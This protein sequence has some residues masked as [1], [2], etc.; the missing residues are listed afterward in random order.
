MVHIEDMLHT[1]TYIDVNNGGAHFHL[2]PTSSCVLVRGATGQS[3]AV[4][5]GK[6]RVESPDSLSSAAMANQPAPSSSGITVDGRGI[7]SDFAGKL[8]ATQDNFTWFGDAGASGGGSELD[9][10]FV[11]NDA[12]SLKI[13]ITGN[14]ETNGNYW[15][16]FLQTQPEGTGTLTATNGPPSGVI[17]T[18]Y[19]TMMDEGFE[20]NWCLCLNTSGGV[21]YVDLVDLVNN[22]CRYMGAAAVN[23][24]SGVLTGGTN[25]NGAL[26]AFDNTNTAGVTSDSGR[27]IEQTGIDAATATTG[28]EIS[29]PFADIGLSTSQV[30]VMALL[31]GNAG[32]ISDQSLPGFGGK[33]YNPGTPPI[34]FD[35]IPATQYAEVTLSGLQFAPQPSI[36]AARALPY[37]TAVSLPASVVTGQYYPLW[38]YYIE[39]PQRISG[40]RVKDTVTGYLPD[41]GQTVTV[42]GFVTYEGGEKVINAVSASVGS[43]GT[44][45]KPLAMPNQTVGGSAG[46]LSIPARPG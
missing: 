1:D 35:R 33:F 7:P 22:T 37:G 19:G 5:S 15:L 18:I 44:L 25:P 32:Y 43:T 8:V 36:A 9:Q 17:G 41:K 29:L 10:L 45:P 34:D 6:W 11:T 23:S 30:G 26:A 16:V 4:E 2:E 14:L 3:A 28:A 42:Q 39:D 13:G 38:S 20:P 21:L 46:G 27:S 12:S 40:V 24:G 31:T